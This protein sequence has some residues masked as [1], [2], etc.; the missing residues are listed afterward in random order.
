MGACN[1]GEEGDCVYAPISNT[2]NSYWS[3]IICKS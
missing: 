3:I 1:Y 2:I